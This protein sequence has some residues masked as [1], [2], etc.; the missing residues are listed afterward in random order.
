MDVFIKIAI[1][2]AGTWL[3]YF[4]IQK[5]ISHVQSK[6]TRGKLYFGNVLLI[7]AVVC[8][9]I[10]IGMLYVL[11]FIDHGGQE[12]PILALI[13]MFGIFGV[14]SLAD[15]IWTKG[16]FNTDGMGFQ[17]LWLGRREYKWSELTDISFNNSLYW[18]VLKFKDKKPARVSV[19]LHGHTD[20]LDLIEG[21]DN[22]KNF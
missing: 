20:L 5:S 7:T 4:L 8:I 12:L 22:E 21:L 6:D 9:S 3:T 1:S 10:V 11:F 15:Y 16:Y 14:L 2:V 17:S 18:Y 13:L 19:Y